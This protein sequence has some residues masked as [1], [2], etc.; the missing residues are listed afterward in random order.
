MSAQ[1]SIFP[2]VPRAA[3]YLS[4]S[5]QPGVSATDSLTCVEALGIDDFIVVGIGEPLIT[6][7]GG[8]V[9]DLRTFPA[10]SGPGVQIPSTQHAL[11]CWLRGDNQG[12]LVIRG[13]SIV[14]SLQNEFQLE[15]SLTHSNMEM[16]NWGSI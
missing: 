7:W 1:P 10:L 5:S 8:V 3:R 11:W 15:Q 6:L 2:G 16:R 4:F 14:D 9:D 12:E 13:N